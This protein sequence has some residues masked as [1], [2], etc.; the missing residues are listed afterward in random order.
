ME[1]EPGMTRVYHCALC[2]ADTPHRIC[3]RK[4]DRY[5]IA[6]TSC[7]G[8]ALVDGEELF[9]YQVRWEEELRQILEQLAD[10][11]GSGDDGVP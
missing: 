7:P 8:G 9:L 4:D 5:A 6:C 2:G 3:H 11:D 10:T 1:L